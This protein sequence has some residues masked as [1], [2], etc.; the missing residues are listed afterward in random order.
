MDNL[1]MIILWW[2][3]P[4]MGGWEPGMG[5]DSLHS[6]PVWWLWSYDNPM[7]IMLWWYWGLRGMIVCTSMV[8]GELGARHWRWQ[9]SHKSGAAPLYAASF[10]GRLFQGIVF[11]KISFSDKFLL[12]GSPVPEARAGLAHEPGGGLRQGV[13]G[14][15]VCHCHYS[16][17][18]SIIRG[19]YPKY[20]L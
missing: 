1:M 12:S 10:S 4:D 18:L 5:D 17:L 15:Q 2:W 19:K 14:D 7:I 20:F 13:R 9:D 16:H 6:I 11:C 8:T 3:S